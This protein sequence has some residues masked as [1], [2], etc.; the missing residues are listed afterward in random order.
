MGPE[1]LIVLGIAVLLFGSARLPK[2]ARSFGE[3]RN[4]FER[5]RIERS[6]HEE[7]STK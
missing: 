7:G 1:V 4:E 6:D 3:A 5:G 2:L